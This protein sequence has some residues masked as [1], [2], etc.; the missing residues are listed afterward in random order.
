MEITFLNPENASLYTPTRG[1]KEAAGFDLYYP[2]EEKI[3]I[4][5][6]L[7]G[8]TNRRTIP[9]GFRITSLPEG[10]YGRIAPR[11]GLAAKNGI[12]V[13]A[14]IVDRD[15]FGELKVVLFNLD[16]NVDKL[17]TKGDRIAQLILEKYSSEDV[18]VVEGDDVPEPAVEGERGAGGFGSTGN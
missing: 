17:I 5:R 12:D 15:F 3:V 6:A 10:T 8:L 7:S 11:S 16:P 1:S 4:P 9:L 13:G 14:G 18:W 2:S